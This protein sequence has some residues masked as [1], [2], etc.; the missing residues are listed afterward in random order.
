MRFDVVD[1]HESDANLT[2]A[3]AVRDDPPRSD[4]RAITILLLRVAREGGVPG[5]IAVELGVGD[6]HETF[7]GTRL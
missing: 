5:R 4:N 1:L 2:V 3:V 6:H 7:S